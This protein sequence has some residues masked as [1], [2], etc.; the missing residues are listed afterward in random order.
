MPSPSPSSPPTHGWQSVLFD[1]DGTLVDT[2]DDIALALERSMGDE[3]LT[4][5][6]RD[7]VRLMIGKGAPNLV[8]KALRWHADGAQ[9]P[10]SLD[11]TVDPISEVDVARHGRLLQGFFHHYAGLHHRHESTARVYDGVAFCLKV[12]SDMGT[13]MAVVTNKRH[14]FAEAVLEQVGLRRHFQF[15]VGGDTCERRKPDP[16]PLH[17]ACQR[18]GAAHTKV[19]MVGD[20]VNDVQAARAGGMSVVCVPYGYNEGQDVRTLPFDALLDD[21]S[22]LPGWLLTLP[23]DSSRLT[24]ARA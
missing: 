7:D 6:A 3:G 21:L 10:V 12:L 17:H 11:D 1:L 20:S 4:S 13:R 19:L 15:L 18:L 9:G 14:T 5:P 2:A 16:M 8:A 22:H 23:P 24:A